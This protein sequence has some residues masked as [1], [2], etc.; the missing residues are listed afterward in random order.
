MSIK[1]FYC[2]FNHHRPLPWQVHWDG[3]RYISECRHCSRSIA[4]R[5]RGGWRK[6]THPSSFFD[7]EAWV[8]FRQPGRVRQIA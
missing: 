1:R 4:R 7:R 6:L 5:P 3:L 8:V 2:L